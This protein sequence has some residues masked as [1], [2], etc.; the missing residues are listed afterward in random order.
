MLSQACVF[1]IS[2]HFQD[3]SQLDVEYMREEWLR[4]EIQHPTST[5]IELKRFFYKFNVN[6]VMDTDEIKK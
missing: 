4:Y 1:N 5:F 6:N 2:R 3:S